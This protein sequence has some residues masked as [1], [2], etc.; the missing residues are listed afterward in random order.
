MNFLRCWSCDVEPSRSEIESRA[1]D[2]CGGPLTATVPPRPRPHAPRPG[3][4]FNLT[5]FLGGLTFLA[6]FVVLALLTRAFG[7]FEGPPQKIEARSLLGVKSERDLPRAYVTL[8]CT[9]AQEVG[10]RYK[11]RKDGSRVK[12]AKLLALPVEDRY[13]L[14]RVPLDH[15][16]GTCPASFGTKTSS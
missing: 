13:L 6:T 3:W 14:V 16:G 2:L 4:S 7:I 9:G 11:T 15:Q 5:R 12:T 10:S 8:D 1:C